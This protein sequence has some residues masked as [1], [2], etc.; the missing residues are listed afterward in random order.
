MLSITPVTV[1]LGLKE[2]LAWFHF[3]DLKGHLS[4]EGLFVSLLLLW[5][6][7]PLLLSWTLASRL[8]YW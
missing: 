2:V 8:P 1:P 4:L 7:V 5:T 6:L 3:S